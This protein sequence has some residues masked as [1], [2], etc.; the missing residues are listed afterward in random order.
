MQSAFLYT[1]HP[2][3]SS[4]LTEGFRKQTLQWRLDAAEQQNMEPVKP[5]CENQS[6]DLDQAMDQ[7]MIRNGSMDQWMNGSMD[8]VSE[9]NNP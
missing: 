8:L 9:K 4:I 1:V 3:H 2:W 5:I 6:M 7:W